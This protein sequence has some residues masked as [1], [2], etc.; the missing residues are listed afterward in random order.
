M[1][2]TIARKFLV[3]VFFSALLPALLAV[4]ILLYLLSAHDAMVMGHLRSIN[5]DKNKITEAYKSLITEKKRRFIAETSLF[6]LRLSEKATAENF[7][8]RLKVVFKEHKEIARI[9]LY[10]PKTFLEQQTETGYETPEVKA[11]VIHQRHAL[12]GPGFRHI[13][14]VRRLS[15]GD[16]QIVMAT[17]TEALESY[18]KLA[19]IYEENVKVMRIFRG[20]RKYYWYFFFVVLAI[21]VLISSTVSILIL[22]NVA[23]KIKTLALATRNV[24]SGDLDTR[25]PL[26]GNDELTTLAEDFN[27][28]VFELKE[29]RNKIIYLERMGAWQ[30]VARNLAHEIK[31]PLTP[32]LLAVQQIEEKTPCGDEKFQQLVKTASGIVKEEVTTLRRLVDTF[33]NLARLPDKKLEVISLPQFLHELEDLIALTWQE[34]IFSFHL[35]LDSDCTIIGDKM[36]LKRAFVNIVENGVQAIDLG[37]GGDG[38]ITIDALTRKDSAII[39]IADNGPGIR[40]IENIFNP[41]YTTKDGG[42]GLGLPLARKICMDIGGDL[43]AE[44]LPEGGAKMLIRLPLAKNN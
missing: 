4:M 8:D 42:T 14:H 12:F 21:I 34:T 41:Y 6:S 9:A 10:P 28:M 5:R 33:G 18:K 38:H 15:S 36:L 29:T 22:K 37:T 2:R 1:R 11:L 26:G 13:S 3:V 44:N 40:E 24:A 43:R 7:H 39:G 19:T 30:E 16:L 35:D 17:G 20:L 23:R 27:N 32:I 25:V 31:N